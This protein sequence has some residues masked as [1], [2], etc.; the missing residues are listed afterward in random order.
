MFCDPGGFLGCNIIVIWVGG[1][2]IGFCALVPTIMGKESLVSAL[3]VAVSVCIGIGDILHTKCIDKESIDRSM[4]R[5]IDVPDIRH[6]ID[7]PPVIASILL[8]YGL[9]MSRPVSYREVEAFSLHYPV[10]MSALEPTM[11][12]RGRL[13]IVDPEEIRIQYCL[14]DAGNPSNAVCVPGRKVPEDPIGNV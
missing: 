9:Y 6:V 3:K 2:G 5:H 1:K 11:V 8:V 4:D 14:D 13:C 12:V 10:Q 7:V